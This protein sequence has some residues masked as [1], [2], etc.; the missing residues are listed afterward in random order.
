MTTQDP[1]QTERQRIA[2]AKSLGLQLEAKYGEIEK[3]R[4]QLQPLLFTMN[5]NGLTYERMATLTG[6]RP[7]TIATEI[8]RHRENTG[9]HALPR[10]RRK[11]ISPK[12]RAITTAA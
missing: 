10:G 12:R 5:R 8:S 9:Q 4:A 11:G 1:T 2:T 3:L 7:S 6:I